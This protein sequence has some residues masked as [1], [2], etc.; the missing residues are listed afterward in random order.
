LRK[1]MRKTM[2]TSEPNQG[3]TLEELIKHQKEEREIGKRFQFH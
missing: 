3:G 1:V 2:G